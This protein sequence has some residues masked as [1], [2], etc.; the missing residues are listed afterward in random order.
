MPCWPASTVLTAFAGDA[1]LESE[2]IFINTGGRAILP[3]IPGLD[4]AATLT[5]ENIMDLTETSEHLIILGGDMQA[6]NLARCFADFRSRVTIIHNQTQI[7]PHED[8]EISAELQNVLEGEGIAF[9]LN[10]VTTRIEQTKGSVKVSMTTPRVR[11]KFRV[12]TFCA[13][14]AAAQIPMISD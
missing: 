12:A 8:I 5:N 3:P 7:V 10:A 1:Q 13:P 6:W 4:P 14:S 11:S 9:R 2:K